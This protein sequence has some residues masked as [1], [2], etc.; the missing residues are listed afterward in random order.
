MLPQFSARVQLQ[1]KRVGWATGCLYWRST[2]T[3]PQQANCQRQ[4][5]SNDDQENAKRTSGV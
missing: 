3:Q 4:H 5:R 2:E 1:L